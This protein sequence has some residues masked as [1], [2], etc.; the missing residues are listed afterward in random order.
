M[1][2]EKMNFRIT[3]YCPGFWISPMNAW[4]RRL[5]RISTQKGF[6]PADYTLVA[7][8]GAGAQHAMAIARKLNV[9]TVLVPSDAGLL[10]AFGLQQARLEQIETRQMLTLLNDVVESLGESFRSWKTDGSCRTGKT[11]S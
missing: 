9:K 3:R 6:D 10:S 8:G 11:G 5:G 4:L 1:P 2:R 7:F